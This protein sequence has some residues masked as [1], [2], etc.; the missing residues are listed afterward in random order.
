MYWQSMRNCWMCQTA[1]WK[2]DE[3]C[4]QCYVRGLHSSGGEGALMWQMAQ[5]HRQTDGHVV[6]LLGIHKLQSQQCSG[7]DIR[8]TVQGQ[9]Y[10][11][12]IKNTEFEYRCCKIETEE[13]KLNS[14]WCW[15]QQTWQGNKELNGKEG[16]DRGLFHRIN[17]SQNGWGWNRPVEAVPSN[18]IAQSRVNW[19]RLLHPAG[20]WTSP[21][22]ETP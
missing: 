3:G 17:E 1:A 7:N 18:P 19:S 13:E 20:F 5:I 11:I 6:D 10:L 21:W 14:Y 8:S 2:A 9:G 22:K 12:C 16:Q 4:R 15:T